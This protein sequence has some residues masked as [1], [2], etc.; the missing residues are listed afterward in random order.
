MGGVHADKRQGSCA[1]DEEVTGICGDGGPDAGAGNRR[2]CSGV[3]C[4]ER[5]CSAS[6]QRPALA[7][8]L[9]CSGLLRLS[10]VWTPL[11]RHSV[12]GFHGRGGGIRTPEPLL[13]KRDF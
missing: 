7:A 3:Q 1:A 12:T 9:A 2:E 13:P 11:N 6:P 4:A 10:L 5:G 8:F